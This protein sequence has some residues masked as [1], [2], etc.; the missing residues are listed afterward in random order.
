MCSCIFQLYSYPSLY[1]TVQKKGYMDLQEAAKEDNMS[2]S[3]GA[4]LQKDPSCALSCSWGEAD[5]SSFL[6]RG[7]NYLEDHEKV[8]YFFF[9]SLLILRNQV[10]EIHL[11]SSK[12]LN[13]VV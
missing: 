4:T 10:I 6:I 7:P 1:V 3:Y 13:F 2:C 9:S 12:V 5:P 8:F 11:D